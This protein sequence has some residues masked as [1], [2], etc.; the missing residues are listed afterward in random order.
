MIEIRKF[1]NLQI[2]TDQGFKDFDGLARIRDQ[3]LIKF[4]FEDKTN[5]SVTY[6]HEFM[7]NGTKVEACDLIEGEVLESRNEFKKII[8]IEILKEKE[9]VFDVLEVKDIHRYY[10]NDILSHNCK[11]IGSSNTLI[12][13]DVLE[14]MET[15]DPIDTKW[16]GVFQIYE[17]PVPDALY[18][19]G[20]DSC[21]GTG[22]DYG[23]VQVLKINSEYDV[24]Q[25]A[26]FRHNTIEVSKFSQIC[27]SISE[28]YNNAYMMIE[29]NGVGAL[30]ANMIWNEYEYDYIINCDKKGLGIR[31]TKKSKLAANLLLKRYAE[32]GWLGI[33]DKQTQ[34]EL[35][36][37]EEVKP[38][39]FQAPEYSHDDCVTSLLWALYFITTEFFDGK[40][41]GVK[42][43]DDKFKIDNQWDND[44]PVVFTDQDYYAMDTDEENEFY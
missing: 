18:I 21:E 20:I 28:F 33:R 42:N 29:N 9:D 37:Y 5:I 26:M 43:I 7:I 22:M 24:D 8:K 35:S 39:V 14:R 17:H 13:S 3:F 44:A 27:I 1:D 30:V 31:S 32:N 16:N 10:V 6:H 11:F 12:D 38:N 25:V 36:L 40:S 2:E 19:L 23:V 41:L 4:T 15:Q 34:Y